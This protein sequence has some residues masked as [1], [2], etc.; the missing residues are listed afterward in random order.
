MQGKMSILYTIAKYDPSKVS[1]NAESIADVYEHNE[2]IDSLTKEGADRYSNVL[3][4]MVRYIIEYTGANRKK[5][6]NMLLAIVRAFMDVNIEDVE[7]EDTLYLVERI[8]VGDGV[9]VESARVWSMQVSAFKAV[10][11]RKLIHAN[12]D[13]NDLDL[14]KSKFGLDQY[15]TF[16][17]IGGVDDSKKISFVNRY[18]HYLSEFYKRSESPDQKVL[19]EY[20]EKASSPNMLASF[21]NQDSYLKRVFS[22]ELSLRGTLEQ[23][24][25]NIKEHCDNILYYTKRMYELNYIEDYNMANS[26]QGKSHYN[27][28]FKTYDKCLQVYDRYKDMITVDESIDDDRIGVKIDKEDGTRGLSDRKRLDHRKDIRKHYKMALELIK[29]SAQ[30]DLS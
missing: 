11:M 20:I 8:K 18:N 16:V 12:I 30:D 14:I 4:S 29:Q 10:L 13:N 7:D 6:L 3:L 19:D 27:E 25:D 17:K 23:A 24:K 21:R 22:Y 26:G 5:K 15:F 28:K 1:D 2:L 9:I